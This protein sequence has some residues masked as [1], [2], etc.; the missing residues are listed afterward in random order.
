MLDYSHQKSCYQFEETFTVYLQAKNQLH[1]SRVPWNITN[2]LQTC[3]F[4]YFAHAWLRRFKVILSTCKKLSSLSVA[5]INFILFVFLKIF[6]NS[7]TSYFGYFGDSWRSSKMMLS[8]CRKTSIF[9][10]IRKVNF[11][12]Y[13]FLKIL[14]FKESCYLI[15]Q[16]HFQEPEF[17]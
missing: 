16:L 1:P 8:T 11:I 3:Y 5:K 10:C 14:F 7:Q 9:I 15:D 2:I 12:T 13:F 6:K 17:S 4:E